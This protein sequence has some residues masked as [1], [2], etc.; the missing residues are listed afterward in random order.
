MSI[1]TSP[2]FLP[3]HHVPAPYPP[4]RPG[5][6]VVEA[7]RQLADDV[8]RLTRVLSEQIAAKEPY[9]SETLGIGP[10]MDSVRPNILAI[11]SAISGDHDDEVTAPPR[12]TG[13]RRAEQGA[14]LAVVQRAYR[15]GMSSIWDELVKKLGSDPSTVQHLLQSAAT[16]WNTLDEYLEILSAAYREFEVEQTQRNTRLREVALTALFHGTHAT[17]L[18]ISGVATALRLP[19]RG[20]FVVVA[21]DPLPAGKDGALV[22]TDRTLAAC[23]V[24]TAW[25]SDI[26]GEVGLIALSRR[27]PIERLTDHLTTLQLGR[28]GVSE[29]F[30]SVSEATAAAVDA[31]AARGAA[32][33]GSNAVMRYEQAR[34]AVLLAS[35]QEVSADLVRDVLG[36]LTVLPA[37]EQNLL[38]GTLRAWFEAKGSTAEAAKLLHC[39]PNTVRYR[40]AKLCQATGRTPTEPIDAAHLYLAM[41]ARRVLTPAAPSKAAHLA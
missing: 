7:C 27:Y 37:D 5:A 22:S 23:G 18:T 3:G 29:I 14:P 25:R 38:M 39:H 33:P 17:G 30:T 24:H 4:D 31:R 10:L 40:M 19:A 32:A 35:E 12:E 8:D 11:L 1:H 21:T 6:V 16:F 41:E 9:Y 28:V 2:H 20:T 26:D 13:R 36:G 15:L 34:V